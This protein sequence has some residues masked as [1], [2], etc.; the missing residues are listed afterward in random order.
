MAPKRTTITTT[1]PMIDA[2]IKAQIAQGVAT[3]LAKYEANRG[4]GNG[5]DSHDSGSGRRRERAA[6]ECTYSDFLKCQPLNFKG[7][8]EV[9][10]YVGGLPGMIHESVMASKPKT[11]QDAI[12]FATELVDQKIRTF[13]DHQ[14]DLNLCALNATTIMMGSV[15]QGATIARK[16]SIWPV[17][18]GV[19]L[20]AEDK[21]EEKRLEDVPI[22]RDFPEVFPEDLLG[23]PP[24]RQVEFQ[25]DLIPDVAHVAR[26]PY[27]FALSK[28]KE[29]TP[30]LALPEGDENF[31]VYCD[32]SYK[33]LAPGKANV[34]VDTL[35]KK[36]RIMPLRVRA[37]VMTIGLDLPKQILEAQTEAR[38]P[39]NLKAKDKSYADVRSKPLDFQ[40]EDRVMLK[41][42]PWKG[43]IRFEIMDREVKRLRQSCIP[44]IKVRWNSRR[45]PEFTW[46]CEDQFKKKY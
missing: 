5:D 41:V 12:E 45:G 25:I 44:I 29:F 9:K 28:T 19:L 17:I 35:S 42:S 1:T 18:V 14:E 21:S 27:L 10:K 20:M 2:A 33:G 37:L 34:V 7:S 23:I 32:A 38:K 46:E 31:I 16:L 4:C 13:A 15:H 8:N 11:M 22:I 30:I 36:E 43:V 26:A 40:V 3:A 6:R 24:T 39:E